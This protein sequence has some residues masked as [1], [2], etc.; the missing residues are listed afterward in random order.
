MNQSHT[1][2]APALDLTIRCGLDFVYDAAAPTPIVLIIQPRDGA[3][4][5]IEA[6]EL[7]LGLDLEVE[8]GEDTHGNVVH[9][10]ILPPGRTTI[11][12]DALIAVPSVREDFGAIDEPVP[13]EEL[14]P[15]L[16][17]YT[18]PSRYCDSD[19]LMNFAFEKF[20]AVPHGCSACR[21][22]ATGCTGISSTASVP[23]VLTTSASEIIGQGFGRLPRLRPLRGGAQP[24]L[25][26][27]HALRHRL[28]AGCGL[29]GPRHAHGFSRL[30]GGLCRAS[31][32]DLRCAFQ[33]AAHRADQDRLRVGCGGWRLL[34]RVWR[35]DAFVIPGLGA[36][37]KVGDPIDMSKRL[38]GTPVLRF[39]SRGMAESRKGSRAV[40]AERRHK[41]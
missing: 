32:A 10:L 3:V 38:D 4:Q 11:R 34:D 33:C 30:H 36:E 2:P 27:P 18:L 22:F 24:L 20:G 40:H 25:Q 1:S 19:K 35:G 8:Q 23:A 31:L 39:P 21:R 15:D 7:Q 28:C 5:R 6:E 12:H 16:L 29:R 9:R 26:Y 37:V 14:T 13:V 17:R 41:T